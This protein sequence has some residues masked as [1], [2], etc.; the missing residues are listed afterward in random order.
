MKT[1]N[2]LLAELQA[3]FP[4]NPRVRMVF[5]DCETLRDVKQTICWE[6]NF[7]Q[8]IEKQIKQGKLYQQWY[9]GE[10]YSKDTN[11]IE[12]LRYACYYVADK[13]GY[14]ITTSSQFHYIGNIGKN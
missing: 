14:K 3:E 10:L 7:A 4:M 12:R 11:D 6:L 5:K 8:T 9:L 13:L 1:K 2:Q